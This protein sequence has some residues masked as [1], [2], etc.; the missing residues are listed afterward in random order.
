M[1]ENYDLDLFI[2]LSKYKPT[3]NVTPLENFTTE[4]FVYMLKY[5]QKNYK[6]AAFEILKLFDIN[7]K[8]KISSIS[9]QNE[10]YVDG[11]KLKPDIEIDLEDRVVFIEVKVNSPLHS[12]ILNKGLN[13]QLEDYQQI[14]FEDKKTIVYSLTKYNID[15]KIKQNIRWNQISKILNRIK[16]TNQLLDNFIEFLKE[17]NMGEQKAISM[18]TANLMSNYY[19]YFQYL[20]D[21][22]NASAFSKNPKYQYGSNYA[23]EDAFGYNIMTSGIPK[24]TNEKDAYYF[25]G[26]IKPFEQQLSF[27]VYLGC[28]KKS[29]WEKD[30]KEDI[31]KCHPIIKSLDIS[32]ISNLNDYD[33]QLKIG[34][35]WLN[36]IYDYLKT[37]I[38]NEYL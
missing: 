21:I 25:L 12:S 38:K 8:E 13:D 29:K 17:N 33:E 7:E 28:L 20:H 2:N 6:T 22:F 18:D 23:K 16:T 26:L 10:Y 5:L 27:Q 14:T 37:I 32:N 9:T 34:T 19:A 31:H 30:W 24:S 15:S 35:I 11:T 4:L 3:E 1:V 36:E